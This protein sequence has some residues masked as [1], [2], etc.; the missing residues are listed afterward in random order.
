[1]QFLAELAFAGSVIITET[2]GY[3]SQIGE[4]DTYSTNLRAINRLK[5]VYDC[6]LSYETYVKICHKILQNA[7][8]NPIMMKVNVEKFARPYMAEHKLQ[9][10]ETL[11]R[12]IEVFSGTS[13]ISEVQ[14]F[15]IRMDIWNSFLLRMYQNTPK[16]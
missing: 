9:P 6:P 16:A 14:I 2:E 15:I 13:I 11:Y 1:M 3:Q 7:I 10:D 5:I 12:Y 8:R 4:L